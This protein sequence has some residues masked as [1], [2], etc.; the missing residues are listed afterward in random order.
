MGHLYY[1]DPFQVIQTTKLVEFYTL[2]QIMYAWNPIL[3]PSTVQVVLLVSDQMNNPILWE[4]SFQDK[5]FITVCDTPENALHTC[6]VVDPTLIIV[7]TNLPHEERL[8]FC[9]ILRTVT[10]GPILLLVTN[11]D[12]EQMADIYNIGIQECLLKPINPVYLVVKS[13]SCLW[14]RYWLGQE[15]SQLRI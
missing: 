12:S 14:R 7:D 2:E 15:A 11:Y 6:K 8:E 5:G 10:S 13:M 3:S 4:S 9:T 1:C